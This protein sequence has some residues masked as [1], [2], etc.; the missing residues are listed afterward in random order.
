LRNTGFEIDKEPAELKKS[1][2]KKSIAKE[3]DECLFAHHCLYRSSNCA[4]QPGGTGGGGGPG[5]GAKDIG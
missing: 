1:Q 3:R 4:F 5:G 2:I